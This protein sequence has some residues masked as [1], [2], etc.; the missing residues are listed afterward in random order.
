MGES[1]ALWAAALSPQIMA[2]SGY[3]PPLS[4]ERMQPAWPN[5][6]GKAALIHTSQED[7]GLEDPDILPGKRLIEEGA[8]RLPCTATRVR[9]MRSSTMSAQR[10]TTRPPRN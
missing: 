6:H 5:Y 1:L 10:F 7:G 9:G 2:A 4:W 3:Y 8:A